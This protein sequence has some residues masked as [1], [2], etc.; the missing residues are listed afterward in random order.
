MEGIVNFHHD[1][2]FFLTAICVFV[3]Y[4]LGRSIVLYNSETLKQPLIVVHAPI[5]EIV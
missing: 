4:M 5:L 1:L 3:F 2:F